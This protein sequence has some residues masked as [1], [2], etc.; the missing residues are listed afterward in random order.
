MAVNN[1]LDW[2]WTE[3]LVA[4]C[5]VALEKTT[6]S[7]SHNRKSRTVSS[8]T[9]LCEV[10][11]QFTNVSEERAAAFVR[12]DSIDQEDLFLIIF[13]YNFLVFRSALLKTFTLRHT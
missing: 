2:I 13:S 10:W 4:Y 11:Y 7:L 9:K 5:E 6:K 8:D 12:I 1:E 3:T